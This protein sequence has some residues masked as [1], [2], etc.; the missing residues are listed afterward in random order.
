MNQ[1][2]SSWNVPY[3]CECICFCNLNEEQL[4]QLERLR[5]NFDILQEYLHATHLLKLLD[6]MYKYEKDT[7]CRMEGRTDRQTDG[8]SETNLPNNFIMQGIII[9]Q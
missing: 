6:K 3:E 9:Q 7:E 4:E 1:V 2:Y 8:W 5:S